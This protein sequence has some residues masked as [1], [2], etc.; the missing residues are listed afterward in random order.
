MAGNPH[1]SCARCVLL[2]STLPFHSVDNIHV[3]ST[4]QRPRKTSAS[5]LEEAFCLSGPLPPCRMP[6]G[7]AD[8]PM[9]RLLPCSCLACGAA[10]G[11]SLAGET[12]GAL[13]PARTPWSL[14]RCAE[15]T[16]A[17]G[18]SAATTVIVTGGGGGGGG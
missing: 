13:S 8:G 5:S 17:A 10:D 12:S 3:S 1:A 6:L 2:L 16:T 4:T 15:P 11:E 9:A 14:S 18:R 7:L